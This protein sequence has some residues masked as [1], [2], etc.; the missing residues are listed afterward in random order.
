MACIIQLT[1]VDTNSCVKSLA[2]CNL[3]SVDPQVYKHSQFLIT[4]ELENIWLGTNGV[5]RNM[6]KVANIDLV[7]VVFFL[8]L[9]CRFVEYKCIWLQKTQVFLNSL[10]HYL[11]PDMSG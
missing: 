4:G 7:V 1:K 8:L 3:S 6:E 10:L 2:D 5:G 9:L 11:S